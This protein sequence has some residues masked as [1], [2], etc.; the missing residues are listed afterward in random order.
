VQTTIIA[1]M[2]DACMVRL[3]WVAD[4]RLISVEQVF[5]ATNNCSDGTGRLAR[6]NFSRIALPMI[7]PRHLAVDGSA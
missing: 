3:E 7:M 2:R 1:C 5:I 6:R 4:H